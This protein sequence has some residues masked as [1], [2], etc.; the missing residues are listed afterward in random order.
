MINKI[1]KEVEEAT[2]QDLSSR[3]RQRELTPNAIT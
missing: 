3:R 2:M 1:R